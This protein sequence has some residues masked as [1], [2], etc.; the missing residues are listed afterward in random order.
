M[1]GKAIA[2]SRQPRHDGSYRYAQHFRRLAIAVAFDDDE[3]QHRAV[4]FRQG[5]YRLFQLLQ[6]ER[7]GFGGRNADILGGVQ[8]FVPGARAAL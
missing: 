2:R 3:H 7:I 8:R 4:I 1:F 6:L 5:V